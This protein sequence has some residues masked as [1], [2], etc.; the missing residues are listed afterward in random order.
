MALFKSNNTSEQ[1]VRDIRRVQVLR[2]G[3]GDAV[4]LERLKSLQQWQTQRM[5][6]SY[7]ELMANAHYR[8][9]LEFFL[10]DIFRG[11]DFSAIGGR[12]DKVSTIVSKLFT[13]TDMLFAVLEFNAVTGELDQLMTETLFE[14]MK[15]ERIT[16]E[17][18]VQ[19]CHQAQ[20]FDVMHR[21][22]TL[23]KLFSDDLNKTVRS[24]LV[25]AAIKLA[26]LPAEKAGFG[27]LYQMIERGFSALSVIE[28][29]EALIDQIIRHEMQ[30]VENMRAKDK[31]PF[32]SM[33]I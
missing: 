6:H 22:K 5:E 24:K 10:H 13:G 17:N 27:N 7:S 30:V 15:V 18:Y 26:K 31:D 16:A 19:A 14:Q 11:I 3:S 25:Y 23:V 21:Q 2:K 32:R 8:P 28:N 20:V 12:L 4:Y 29:P 9:L 1:I 33:A